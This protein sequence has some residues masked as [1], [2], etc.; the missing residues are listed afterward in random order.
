MVVKAAG[1]P[2]AMT[3]AIRAAIRE[4]DPNQPLYDVLPMS[5]FIA[6]TLLAQRLNLM[7][8][9]SFAVLAL[10]PASVGLYAVVSHL[11]V[12][13]SREFGVRLAVGQPAGPPRYGAA[14]E[15]R[16]RLDRPC[17]RPHSLRRD[18]APARDNDSWRRR[19]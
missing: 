18:H 3:P 6:R 15:R 9:G 13:R 14:P 16:P 19:A 17:R 7:L 5:E 11:T 8:V 12:R 1:D 4:V 10:V 2:A